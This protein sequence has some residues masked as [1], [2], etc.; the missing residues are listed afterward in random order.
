VIKVLQSI[1]VTKP[2]ASEI[3]AIGELFAGTAN[4]KGYYEGIGIFSSLFDLHLY[5]DGNN[6]NK[7]IIKIQDINQGIG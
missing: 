3:K 6:E 2:D 5:N 4:Q 1:F 7:P